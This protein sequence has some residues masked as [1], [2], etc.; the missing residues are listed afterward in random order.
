MSD[1]PKDDVYRVSVHFSTKK[2][3]E[4]AYL[5]WKERGNRGPRE[6]F[7]LELITTWKQAPRIQVG[8]L[9]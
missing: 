9:R 3:M 6:R 2:A 7:L 8:D 1:G 4:Q 5:D